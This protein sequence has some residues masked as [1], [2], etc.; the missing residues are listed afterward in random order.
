MAESKVKILFEDSFDESSRGVRER[1][2]VVD[3]EPEGMGYT[4]DT[5]YGY[6][7]KKWLI[8]DEEP[9]KQR[10]AFWCIPERKNGEV[11]PYM[12][13]SARS[14]NSICYARTMVP[15]HARSYTIEFKQWLNDNDTIGFILGASQPLMD[16]DGVEFSYQ[17]QLP[18][19]DTTVK[20][21]YYK[22]V[23]GEGIIKGEAGMKQWKSHRIEV[24]GKEIS[25]Y[26]NGKLLLSGT[27]DSLNP[28]GYFGIR[29]RY[30]RGTRYD[31][32]KISIH[33]DSSAARTEK[34]RNVLFIAV[35]DLRNDLGCYGVPLVQS[36]H[37]DRLASQG[38]QFNRA[39]CQYPLCNPSRA[40][41]LTGLRP[42]STGCNRTEINNTYYFRSK[43]PNHP[44][45]P[46]LFQ[47]KGY[48]VGRI[49]KLYHYGVPREIGFE[50]ALD[51]RQ[52]WQFS[53]YPR[54]EEKNEED[55]LISY[56]PHRSAG[57]ALSWQESKYDSQEHTDGKVTTEAIRVMK[58]LQEEPFFLAVGYYR[59]HV[60]STA[61]PEFFEH[62]PM[63]QIHLPKEP[64]EHFS[65]I[66]EVVF[67]DKM[68]IHADS[69]DLRKFKRAYYATVTFVDAQIGRLLKAVDDLGLRDNT[70]VV[71]WSDHGWMLG[72]HRQWE[73]RVLFE[74][75]ARVPLIIRAPNVMGNGSESNRLVELVD[76]YPTIAE[77]CGIETPR[78]LE[79]KSLTPLL[80]EPDGN[81]SDAAFT[82]VGRKELVGRSIRTS[83]W[84][85]IE[86]DQGR[87][88]AELYDHLVDPKEYVN[89]AK[90]P[91]F[92]E[93]VSTLK[94]RLDTQFNK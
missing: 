3:P 49:G 14:H 7:L 37:I 81:W 41:V 93:T 66:P 90:N 94:Q 82:Q 21:I 16:H 28:G 91:K 25:W 70:I 33:E 54:G 27:A 78:N 46:Q 52:S 55:Q 5:P 42:D 48:H 56:T 89:L 65:N 39:Y 13:Q 68:Q 43:I 11:M 29:Q 76:L 69:E 80:E 57:W 92:Q 74:E 10:R 19:T 17:R 18:G 84:G 6:R 58:D 35:D 51:D 8:A 2:R 22:G 67:E 4:T 45:L 32:V 88:G 40:S 77:L 72:E 36:P 53:I 23:L 9:D 20:D 59:P 86:W 61:P 26:Q 24:Q 85:Y 31:D 30:E 1:N 15:D 50:S 47:R 44:T 79:G 38:V 62:Y 12:Q 34:K 71:L 75:S 63:D 87:Q 60:P 83:R 64:E 73:K